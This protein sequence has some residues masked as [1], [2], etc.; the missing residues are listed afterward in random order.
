[1]AKSVLMTEEYTYLTFRP[2]L[3]K[4][5]TCQDPQG[6]SSK[7]KQHK[8]PHLLFFLYIHAF[9]DKCLIYK[10][11]KVENEPFNIVHFFPLNLAAN[12]HLSR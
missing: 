3:S 5:G 6:T 4:W 1:M 12:F 8:I 2:L 11:I 9:C 7:Y 10:Q